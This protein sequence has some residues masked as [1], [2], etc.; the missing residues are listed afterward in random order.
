M[1][2]LGDLQYY[3]NI[4]QTGGSK[5]KPATIKQNGKM[6]AVA[7]YNDPGPSGITNGADHAC[8]V[9]DGSTHPIEIDGPVVVNGDVIIKGTVKG[10]GTIYAGRNIH[11]VGDLQYDKAPNWPKPDS[12]PEKTAENNMKADLLGLAAKGN[13]VIGNYTDLL[14]NNTWYN[15][16]DHYIGPSFVKPYKCD[17]QG[18][19]I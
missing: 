9:L 11:I 15:D 6:L 13:I 3:R 18:R 17:P 7:C 1:P 10:Q 5:G 4:A 8:L 14:A 16:V 19:R 2:F 12:S